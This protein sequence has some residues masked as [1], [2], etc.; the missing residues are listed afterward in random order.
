MQKSLNSDSIISFL[1]F[2]FQRR[3]SLNS[4]YSLRAFASYLEVSPASLS[5]V[6]SGKR[7]LIGKVRESIIS[8]LELDKKIS[9]SDS[10]SYELI[11]LDELAI[12]SKWHADAVLELIKSKDFKAT[13]SWISKKLKISRDEAK[14]ALKILKNKK[15]LIKSE[16]KKWLDNTS[17][18]TSH[19]S[20]D[21]T[22]SAR[23]NYQLTLLKQ[24]MESIE[25]DHPSMRDHT[26]MMVSIKK[27]N[28]PKAKKLIREFRREFASL[29]DEK[30]NPDAIYELCLNF[31]PLTKETIQ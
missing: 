15:L 23:K 6:L 9:A 26:S 10:L 24:S 31:F 14:S 2:E 13:S 25:N 3:K 16:N 28:I 19:I 7:K 30:E 12:N 5:Q 21:M 20:D 11:Q 17:G 4:S 8:K 18:H 27:E 1:S 29:I 22:N